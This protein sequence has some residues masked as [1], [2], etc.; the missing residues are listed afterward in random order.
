MV[1][2]NAEHRA[3]VVEDNMYIRNRILQ[4]NNEFYNEWKGC[5]VN[6][7]GLYQVNT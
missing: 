2:L 5:L 4:V 7:L 1:R 6:H 3:V